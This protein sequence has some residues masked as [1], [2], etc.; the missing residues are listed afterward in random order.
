MRR[1][2]FVLLCVLLRPLSTSAEVTSVTVDSRSV[3]ADGRSFGPTGPYESIL[4]RV[5][6]VLDTLDAHN[7]RI[8]AREHARRDGDGR[9]RFSSDLSVLR[10]TDPSKGN[11]VLLFQVANRGRGPSPNS[12]VVAGSIVELLMTEGYTLVWIGWEIDVPVPL[13]LIDAPTA[14]LPSVSDDW[15]SGEIILNERASEAFLVDD[16]A[17]RPPVIYP[18]ADSQSATDVL[19][20]RDRFW[21]QSAVIPRDRWRFIV[22]PNN[23]PKLQLDTAFEP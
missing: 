13:L 3:I 5:A 14:L 15:L 17:G 22:G 21:D 9:V 6:F 1:C 19:T 4:G 16:P 11:G 12:D 7:R 2:F 20:V 10:P 8:V 23:L 18:P